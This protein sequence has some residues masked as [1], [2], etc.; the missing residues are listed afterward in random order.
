[1]VRTQPL[2]DLAVVVGDVGIV[3]RLFAAV[4]AVVALMTVVEVAFPQ[5]F[6]N[7]YTLL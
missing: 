4:A 1:M 3:G 2:D 7:I 6:K 5:A